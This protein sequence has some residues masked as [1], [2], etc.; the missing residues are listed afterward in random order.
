MFDCTN[1]LNVNYSINT[2]E[3]YEGAGK[4][5]I[6]MTYGFVGAACPLKD[7]CCCSTGCC[8]NGLCVTGIG[9]YGGS[10]TGRYGC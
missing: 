5:G 2:H 4:S 9:L 10:V 6:G 3:L 8:T 7:G 1:I